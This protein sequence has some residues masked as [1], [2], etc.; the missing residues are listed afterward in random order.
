MPCASN[1]A[2]P[3]NA[4]CVRSVNM[5]STRGRV[6]DADPEKKPVKASGMLETLAG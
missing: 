5:H 6:Q 2:A 4:R 1:L 3:I